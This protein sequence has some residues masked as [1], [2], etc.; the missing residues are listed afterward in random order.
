MP[1]EWTM[2]NSSTHSKEVWSR[3][4]SPMLLGPRDLY[5]GRD[6]RMLTSCTVEAAWQFSKV[7][8]EHAE[9]DGEPNEESNE[10]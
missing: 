7:Y 3:G 10:E 8:P 1:P 6:G 2:V 5:P 9:S 4:L